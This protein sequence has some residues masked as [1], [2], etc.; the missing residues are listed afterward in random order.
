MENNN[1][2]Y[3]E[4]LI[5]I[6]PRIISEKGHTRFLEGCDSCRFIKNDKNIYYTA[7]I[8]RPYSIEIE[9]DDINGNKQN[10]S[11][12]GF[13]STVFSHEYDHL[14]GVLHMDKA[15]EIFQMTLEEMKEYR[16]KN[17]YEVISKDN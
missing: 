16:L 17:P 8:D 15:K 10:K 14:N 9:Y 13:E 5:Y 4:S 12:E 2:N 6:N 7:V 11:I 1:S 3:D